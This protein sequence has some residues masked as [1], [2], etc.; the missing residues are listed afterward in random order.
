LSKDDVAG[1]DPVPISFGEVGWIW[2]ARFPTGFAPWIDC[3]D[4]LFVQ[5]FPDWRDH[6]WTS[7]MDLACGKIG[8][9]TGGSSVRNFN[10]VET[11]LFGGG[12][13]WLSLGIG[14]PGRVRPPITVEA[15]DDATF[16]GAA[17][18]FGL[19]LGLA[20]DFAGNGEVWSRRQNPA[21]SEC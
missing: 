6:R 14:E 18:A 9:Q 2:V 20:T 15:E 16:P 7:R 13:S 17:A 1:L 8:D 19:A 12:S 5:F 3:G 10:H 21:V 4:D 11:Q